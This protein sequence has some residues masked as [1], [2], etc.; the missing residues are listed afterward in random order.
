M[1]SYLLAINLLIILN[2][3]QV[4]ILIRA[5]LPIR[6]NDTRS[7][8]KKNNVESP[9]VNTFNTQLS[10]P[11]PSFLELSSINGNDFH[12][13]FNIPFTSCINHVFNFFLE[14]EQQQQPAYTA[15]TFVFGVANLFATSFYC[16][17]TRIFLL[18][19]R[20]QRFPLGILSSNHLA[21]ESCSAY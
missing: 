10:Q 4:S 9:R 20:S 5:L 7:N 11:Y 1:N 14:H 2:S 15:L 3:S 18:Y 6:K 21:S 17:R 13:V 12:R 19:L 8:F 16:F